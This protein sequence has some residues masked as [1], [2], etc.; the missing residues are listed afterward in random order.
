MR[1]K[2]LTSTL[3]VTNHRNGTHHIAI[4]KVL[5]NL[6]LILPQSLFDQPCNHFLS[7]PQVHIQC[8]FLCSL[9]ISHHQC[10]ISEEIPSNNNVAI[11]SCPHL[12]ASSLN[13]LLP[14]NDFNFFCLAVQY[15]LHFFTLG[16]WRD[17]HNRSY[18]TANSI[19]TV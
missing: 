14:D 17:D 15:L 8:S 4:D 19:A 2:G 6:G 11:H 9:I 5:G 3:K 7:A 16:I 13:L 12:N 18:L 10:L 1:Y